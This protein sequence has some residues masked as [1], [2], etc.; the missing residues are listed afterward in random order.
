MA[1]GD[2]WVCPRC[3]TLYVEDDQMWEEP[4]RCP[5]CGARLTEDPTPEEDG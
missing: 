5:K 3:R 4:G 2:T 1:F